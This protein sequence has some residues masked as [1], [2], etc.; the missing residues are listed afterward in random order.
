M[1]R[2]RNR[3][4]YGISGI[5]VAIM[6][7]LL[8]ARAPLLFAQANE[9]VLGVIEVIPEFVGFYEDLEGRTEVP[10]LL[11][12]EVPLPEHL[13]EFFASATFAQQERYTVDLEAV[14]GCGGAGACTFGSMSG[15][16]LTDQTPK[17]EEMYAPEMETLVNPGDRTVS[18]DP[19][20]P[21]ELVDG[22]EGYFIPWM[23]TAQCSESK[24]YWVQEEFRY[25]VGIE[26]A[27]KED[28][29]ELANSVIR[30][31]PIAEP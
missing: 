23:A 9:R 11:P 13:N 30:N 28:V 4:L 21:V 17:L 8:A 27:D 22:I 29:V 15:E 7:L 24:V 12:T 19:L 25:R 16:V 26:C 10:V 20:G 14:E 5:A 18:S 6:F 3:V 2:R 1:I 31:E